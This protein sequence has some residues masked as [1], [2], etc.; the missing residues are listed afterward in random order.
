[1]NVLLRLVA[2]AA[3]A[4]SDLLGQVTQAATEGVLPD[5][6][7]HAVHANVEWGHRWVL[8]AVETVLRGGHV[9]I[10]TPDLVMLAIFV[11]STILSRKI[12]ATRVM[13]PAWRLNTTS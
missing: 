11:A 6:N 7:I 1:M 3:R 8:T 2:R 13:V 5:Q 9:Q 10:T 4:L 12:S